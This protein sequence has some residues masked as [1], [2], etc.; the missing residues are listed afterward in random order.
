[1]G[2]AVSLLQCRSRICGAAVTPDTQ[3][4]VLNSL[5]AALAQQVAQ[6]FEVV[7]SDP[8]DEGIGRFMAGLNRAVG[9]HTR[10]RDVLEGADFELPIPKA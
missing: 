1:M 4:L 3:E 10:L 7:M 9:V 5:D 6:L 2:E 8:S